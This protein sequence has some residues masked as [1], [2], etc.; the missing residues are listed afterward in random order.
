MEWEESRPGSK[1]EARVLAVDD[2]AAQRRFDHVATEEP[3]EIRLLLRGQTR[4]VAVTM[5]TPGADFELAAGFLYGEGVLR[6][7]DDVR[8][9]TYCVD[10][11]VEPEQRYNIV[12]VE[13][14]REVLPDL[15]PL[16]R[17]FLTTSA[18]GVC[19][20]ANLE[21]LRLRGVPPL[22]AG[23][24]VSP[25]IVTSLP[26]RLRG[27]QG[28]FRSTGGL[29]A[30]ALFDETGELLAVR[31]DVGRHNAVD[32][33]VGWA[34][35]NGKVPL[36]DRLMMVSGRSS[37]EIL[38]KALTAG[39]SIVC[40]ISAPSSL[41]VALAREFGV[42]LIGFL[43][44][45]R[46]N[47]YAGE[48]RIALG[49]EAS[50]ESAMTAMIAF[51]DAQRLVSEACRPLPVETVALPDA[52]G[53][54]A[55]ASVV[56]STDLVPFARSAMDGYAVRSVDTL[57]AS[58][59]RT[60]RLPIA[61][62]IF[63]EKG[64]PDHRAQTA[65][66]IATGAPIPRGADAVIPFEDVRRA[67]DAIDLA[68]PIRAGDHVF[69]PGEDARCGDVLVA[70]GHAVTPSAAGLLAVAGYTSVLV[71]RR[72]R[73][74]II[75]TG[76]EIVAIDTEPEHG[77]VRNSNA[78]ML[79]AFSRACGAEVRLCFAV[80]DDRDALRDALARALDEVDLLV[81]TGGASVG[82]R[83]LVKA[84]LAELGV[85]F[86]FSSVALRPSKP[87][88]FGRRGDA[89]VAVLPG[90]PAAAF[91][92]FA[93]FVRPALL[94]L[95][96]RRDTLYAN[97]PAVLEGSVRTKA[98]RTYVVFGRLAHD[99]TQFVVTPVAN[100]CSALVRTATDANCLIVLPPGASEFGDGDRVIV[101]V[102]DWDR[103]SFAPVPSAVP[104]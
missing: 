104:A 68:E 87:T 39:V 84:T 64:T 74:G 86:L 53:R 45:S 88:G 69:P 7:R 70:A 85:E 73:I 5:R 83:D 90:N 92:G 2:G 25:E 52:L 35:L 21:A 22:S 41:A 13:L 44:G 49:T 23:P 94:R 80:P 103:V 82:K 60:M 51:A 24:F 37:Y 16:E 36:H 77:Q 59:D 46:F 19:G 15:A 91:V 28:I 61:Q 3:L 38:Q 17:H 81:T 79:D 63:A 20:K 97:V 56:A 40:A 31:E 72:P 62:T 32:K 33:L 89:L 67:G 98:E 43:R 18:C 9:I 6:N 26:D 54:V 50:L 71:H 102:L 34:L 8:G 11:S 58:R 47:V 65:S 27:A 95:G 101:H 99:G 14:S 10:R 75:C 55:A 57:L 29:H 66:E 12:N 4:T 42:T 78:P 30:A 76:D 1:A 93:E 48:Q 100:Q 96:G